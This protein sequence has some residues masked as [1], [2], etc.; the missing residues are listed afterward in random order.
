MFDWLAVQCRAEQV[1]TVVILGDLT[2]AKDYHSATLVNRVVDA[3]VELRDSQLGLNIIVLM[4]NHDY[5]L[6]GHAYL[7]FLSHIQGITFV[8]TPTEFMPT[9]DSPAVLALP[10]TRTPA[11][12]WVDL[13]TTHFNYIFMHQTVGGAVA[14]NGQKMDGENVP[15]LTAWGKVYSGDIHVPQTIKGVEYV[16]SPYHVHFGDAFVPR[17]VLIDKRRRAS[18]LIFSD[19]P[20][21]L[22][23]DVE[24]LRELKRSRI[25]PGDHVSLRMHLERAEKHEWSKVRREAVAW[26]E[27]AGA[28]VHGV[29]LV[30]GAIEARSHAI[31]RDSQPRMTDAELVERWVRASDLGADAYETGVELVR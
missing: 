22:A 29:K 31:A 30:I 12:D 20:K 24:T 7:R 28:V 10:H 3:L 5:L 15:D 6:G 26:L 19:A 2:D 17:C 25:H 9:D 18:D 16:G 23:L 8:A 1:R 4:G 13:D 14:S 27:G 21:R 11:K